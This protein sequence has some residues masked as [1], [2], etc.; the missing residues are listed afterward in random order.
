MAASSQDANDACRAAARASLSALPLTID[1]V[2]PLLS[3]GAP[4][5]AGPSPAARRKRRG[6]GVQPGPA[7]VD[8]GRVL[9]ACSGQKLAHHIQQVRRAVHA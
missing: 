8:I 9:L 5:G 7:F 6:A 2:L 3:V 4:G 1:V